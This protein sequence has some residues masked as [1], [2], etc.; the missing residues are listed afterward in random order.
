MNSL[1]DPW[2]II[3]WLVLLLIALCAIV[4][5]GNAVYE[6]IRDSIEHK[7]QLERI[8]EDEKRF[9]AS[10][11]AWKARSVDTINNRRNGSNH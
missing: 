7:K 4:G 8:R 11:A 2:T 9:A 5:L 10:V 3:G 6:S 1:P